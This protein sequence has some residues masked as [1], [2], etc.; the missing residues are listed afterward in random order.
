MAYPYRERHK[1]DAHEWSAGLGFVDNPD[2]GPRGPSIVDNRPLYGPHNVPD[3][4]YQALME[5]DFGEDPK[6]SSDE[7][8]ADWLLFETKIANAGLSCKEAVV[9][10]CVVF[11]Q[12]SLSDAGDYLARAEGRNKSYTRQHIHYLRNKAF[13]KLREALTHD[14]ESEV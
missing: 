12:M 4:Q 9:V 10:D 5:C 6:M 2:R 11:G 1:H 3:N 13:A 14:D 7:R 8:E